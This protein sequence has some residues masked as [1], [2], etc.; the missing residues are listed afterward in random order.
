VQAKN[1][2]CYCLCQQH[3]AKAII[4]AIV[5]TDGT[6]RPQVVDENDEWLNEL[7]VEYGKINGAECLINTSLN[8]GGR[9]IAENADHAKYDLKGHDV[10]LCNI[11]DKT[12][13]LL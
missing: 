1:R 8:T 7:L 12:I 9:P 3:E 5:H 11:A 6:A 10:V 2:R 4:P 13:K